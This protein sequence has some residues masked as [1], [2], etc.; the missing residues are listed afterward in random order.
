MQT[1]GLLAEG[2]YGRTPGEQPVGKIDTDAA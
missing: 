1:N 2:G